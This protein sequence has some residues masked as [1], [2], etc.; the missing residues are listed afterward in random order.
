M[1]TSIRLAAC[2]ATSLALITS[3]NA[4]SSSMKSEIV[5]DLTGQGVRTV[6]WATGYKPDYSWLKLPVFDRK[7]AI[8]HDGGIATDVPGLYVMGLPFLR[9]RKSS[10]ID[11]VGDDAAD[12]AAHL[13]SSLDR[14]AA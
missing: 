2:F 4:Q 14:Q 7:G 1:R 5:I 10:Y 3:A 13:T 9:R 6:I 8:R 12:L 11:G